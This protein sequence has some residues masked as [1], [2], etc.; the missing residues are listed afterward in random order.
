MINWEIFVFSMTTFR[1]SCKSDRRCHVTDMW[2]KATSDNSCNNTPNPSFQKIRPWKRETPLWLL[3]PSLT[4]L[5][6]T[7]CLKPH[8][9]WDHLYQHKQS[10]TKID[11]K[12]ISMLSPSGWN[13][14]FLA[15]WKRYTIL[16]SIRSIRKLQHLKNFVNSPCS[17]NRAW[18]IFF[19]RQMFFDWGTRKSTPDSCLKTIQLFCLC[20]SRYEMI[21]N[22]VPLALFTLGWNFNNVLPR[23]KLF[24]CKLFKQNS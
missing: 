2:M 1:W 3:T 19:V 16:R 17:P 23:N 18:F 9:L 10:K 6:L 15:P 7:K 21:F 20:K 14:W 5:D 12:K 13:L 11:V 22:I 4:R 8:A 24:P